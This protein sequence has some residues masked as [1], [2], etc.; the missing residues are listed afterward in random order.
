MTQSL[1]RQRRAATARAIAGAALLREAEQVET[2]SFG[3]A[4]FLE[5]LAFLQLTKA[6]QLVE[7]RFDTEEAPDVAGAVIV[8]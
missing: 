3:K 8:N 1:A 2:R 4:R 6:A 5:Q 7:P